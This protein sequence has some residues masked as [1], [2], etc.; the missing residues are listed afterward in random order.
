MSRGWRIR[1]TA[2]ASASALALVMQT[3]HTATDA[4]QLGTT[5]TPVGAETAG[6]KDGSIPRWEGKDAP[7]PGWS[8]GKYRG[9]YFKYKD[10][11]PTASIDASNVDKYAS[12]LT[13]GQIALMKTGKGRRMDIYPT[14]RTCGFPDFVY[15]N[16]KK[17]VTEAKLAENGHDLAEANLPGVPFPLPKNGAEVMW[18][19]KLHYNG[20]GFFTDGYRTLVSPKKGSAEWIEPAEREPFYFPWGEKGSKKLT[21]LPP[22]DSMTIFQYLNPA[23]FAGQG[24]L[25]TTSFNDASETFYYFPGQRRVRRL[26][27]YAYDAPQIGMENEYPLDIAFGFYGRIDRF[28]WKLVGKKEIYVQA[29]AFKIYDFRTSNDLHKVMTPDGVNPS[30]LRY[31]LRRVWVVEAAVKPGMRHTSP[32]RT[33]YV[34]E[35]S[36][37][38]A[39]AED[40][41]GQGKLW[42]TRET[43]PIPVWELGGACTFAS[44]QNYDLIDGRYIADFNI[45]G[46]GKD[47][48]WFAEARGDRRFTPDYYTPENLRAMSE[49]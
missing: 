23:A 43:S 46:S 31:E 1:L 10:E 11:K 38:I 27:N 2:L 40:Y 34:D 15:G 8:W 48:Q 33:F 39:A 37:T 19:A 22:N 20:V 28:D 32:K 6:N 35:D 14:H 17:N 12:R 47:I 3:A 29:N 26:P 36:W 21:Q 25:I 16:T 45:M 30:A 13:P 49:R 4:E 5:L 44:F 41:D 9:D 7:L 24:A 42:R 18:N